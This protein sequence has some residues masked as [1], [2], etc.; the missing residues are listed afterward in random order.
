MLNETWNGCCQNDQR[1]ARTC[2]GS[3][4]FGQMTFGQLTFGCH[5][6]IMISTNRHLL[7]HCN[8][9][10][11]NYCRQKKQWPPRTCTGSMPFGQMPFGQLIFEWYSIK[12]VSTY[13][14]LSWLY[15][16]WSN[17]IWSTDILVTQYKNT[18]R[19]LIDQLPKW[20]IKFLNSK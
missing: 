15:V 19:H 12:W 6:I 20:K 7:S 9:I 8:L 10:N 3:V 13:I 18:N 16:F 1:P 11:W 5:S 2:T 4:L 17:D 14:H